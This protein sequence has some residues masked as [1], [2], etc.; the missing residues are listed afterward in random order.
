ML[1]N[2]KCILIYGLSD[3]ELSELNKAGFK[4]KIINK[5]MINMKIKD[6]IIGLKLETITENSLDE[7]IILF[8]NYDDKLLQSA[9]KKVRSIIKGVI[10]AVV[11]PTSSEWTFEYLSEHL[12]EER[13]YIKGQKKEKKVE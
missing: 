1:N 9:V 13:N 2:N 11:T 6:I 12:I 7:K 3:E 8:N 5:E 4:V 10:L